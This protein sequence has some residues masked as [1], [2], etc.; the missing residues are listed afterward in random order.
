MQTPLKPGSAALTRRLDIDSDTYCINSEF[1]RR[2]RARMS[3]LR[4]LH[5]DAQFGRIC[6]MLEVVQRVIKGPRKEMRLLQAR[7]FPTIRFDSA[8]LVFE[9]LAE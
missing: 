2:L 3:R 5:D 8:A 9:T 4:A 6:V 1:G 7:R